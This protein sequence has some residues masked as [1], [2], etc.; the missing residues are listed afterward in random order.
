MLSSRVSNSVASALGAAT[1]LLAQIL[2]LMGDAGLAYPMYFI[3][4]VFVFYVIAYLPYSKL[5]HLLYRPIAIIHAKNVG[6]EAAP[7]A[8][9]PAKAPAAMKPAWRPMTS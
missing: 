2:R 6:R 7:A 4:L 8:A 5:A 9:K 3:H 1:G